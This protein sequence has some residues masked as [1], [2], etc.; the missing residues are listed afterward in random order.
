[1]KTNDNE[2][3]VGYLPKAPDGLA[4]FVKP[5]VTGL[6]A[7]ALVVSLALVFA[8][9]PFPTSNF[10]FGTNRTYRGLVVNRP[11]PELRASDGQYLLVLPG[12]HGAKTFADSFN[13]FAVEMRGSRIERGGHTMIEILPESARRLGQTPAQYIPHV[14]PLGEV[15][16]TGEI[17]DSKCFLG[18]MNP[19]NGKTHRDCAA[20]CISG[21]IPPAFIAKDARGVSAFMLLSGPNGEPL[22]REVLDYVAEPVR[23][24]GSLIRSGGTLVLRADPKQF[25]RSGE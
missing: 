23:I 22:H 21:G 5:M 4:R 11:Y 17:V 14:E 1:M 2:F 3:Y 7:M 15:T 9:H 24:R 19:G 6:I 16:L 25:E 20:R 12:K 10:E 8:Q 13:G 18:V